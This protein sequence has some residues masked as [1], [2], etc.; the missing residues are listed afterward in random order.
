M[1]RGA[2][3]LVGA[4]VVAALIRCGVSAVAHAASANPDRRPLGWPEPDLWDVPDDV[5]GML[6]ELDFLSA[7]AAQLS[8]DIDQAGK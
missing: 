8:A 4:A 7:C 5:P 2:C 6:D 1:R 3:S